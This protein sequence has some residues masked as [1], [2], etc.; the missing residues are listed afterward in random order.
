MTLGPILPTLT[1]T[2][3]CVKPP[4]YTSTAMSAGYVKA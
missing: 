2:A 1:A 4:S 3:L